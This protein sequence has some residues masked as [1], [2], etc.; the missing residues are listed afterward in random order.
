MDHKDNIIK[1]LDILRKQEIANKEPWKARAYAKAIASLKEVES[2]K[3]I[4][5]IKDIPNI[6]E[7]IR[8]KIIELIDTGKLERLDKEHELS[9]V[10]DELTRIHGI[11]PAK[12]KDL[13]ESGI[14]TIE[15]IRKDTSILN[16]SQLIGLKYLEE[17]EAR[18]PRVEIEK[19]ETYINAIFKKINSKLHVTIVGSYRRGAKDSGDIDMIISHDDDPENI[20]NELK[21]IVT[22]MTKEKYLT[23][24]LALGAHKY[25]GVCRLKHHRKHRRIDMLYA[26]AKEYPFSLLYFTGSAEFNIYLR[27]LALAK[28][29]S[30]SEYG[31]KRKKELI[32]DKFETEKDIIEYLGCKYVSPEERNKGKFE[33][34]CKT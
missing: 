31:L 25:L 33:H 22:E 9:K 13:F 5:D 20:E 17:F 26:R 18:I 29:L 14:K 32:K 1:S 23:D 16:K 4:E 28:N 7:S 11:G 2:I 19:H 15:D 8:T 3:S 30:L 21:H 10:V 24:D 34:L 27:N 12:A 6:G